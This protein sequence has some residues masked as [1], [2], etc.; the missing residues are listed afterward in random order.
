MAGEFSGF[1]HRQ[2]REKNR[3][4]FRFVAGEREGAFQNIARWQDPKLIAQHAGR[5]TAVE[6]RHDGVQFKPGIGFQPAKQTRQSGPTAETADLEGA[7]AHGLILDGVRRTA[8]DVR[9]TA[10]VRKS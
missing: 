4:R 8:Y 10:Y 9:R 2:A 3:A 6:H 5:S 7:K 1:Q